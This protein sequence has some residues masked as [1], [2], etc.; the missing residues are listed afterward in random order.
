M[1]GL[2]TGLEM[3]RLS[4]QLESLREELRQGEF[5][6]EVRHELRFEEALPRDRVG[7]M[8]RFRPSPTL[9]PLAAE[10]KRYQSH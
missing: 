2:P 1:V 7:E 3:H 10:V 5:S 9:E 8:S 6:V 4:D